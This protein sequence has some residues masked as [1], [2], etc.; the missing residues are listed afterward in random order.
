M[1][2]FTSILFLLLLPLCIATSRAQDSAIAGTYNGSLELQHLTGDIASESDQTLTVTETAEGKINVTFPSINVLGQFAS[3]SFTVED[4]TV[5]PEGDGSYSLGKEQFIIEISTGTMTS[6][7]GYSSLSGTIF[8]NGEAEVIVKV[9]QNPTMTATTATFYGDI[10]DMATP[11]S[12]AY[13][14]GIELTHLTGAGTPLEDQYVVVKK[15]TSNTVNVT[16]PSISILGRT[17]SGTITVTGVGVTAGENGSY[18]LSKNPF[19][20]NVNG[21]M[22]S[23][24]YP[25]SI[26]SGTVSAEG[27]IKLTVEVIQN[28]ALGALTTA[29]FTGKPADNS[30]FVW[31]TAEWSI[32]DNRTFDSIEEFETAGLTLT[33]PNPTGY[34]LTFLNILAADCEVYVDGNAEAEKASFSGQ[35]GTILTTKY[36]FA[37]GHDYK[38]KVISAV[39]AQ[40]NLATRK[41]DTLSINNDSYTLSFRINGPELQKTIEVEAKMS[42]DIIDQNETPTVSEVNVAEITAALGINDISEADM[43]ALNPDGSYNDHMDYYDFWHAANGEFTNYNGGYDTYAGHNAYP[44]VYCIKINEAADSVTYFFY[45]SWKEYD[46]NESGSIPGIGA[47]TENGS[48]S[49]SVVRATPTTS[50]NSIIWDW[51]NGD[52]TTTQYKRSY[53]VDVDND[54]KASF[55]FVANRKS[56]TVNA[57]LHFVEGKVTGIENAKATTASGETEYYTI[58]GVRLSTPQKGINIVRE[59]DGRTHKILVK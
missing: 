17:E 27:E 2:R 50:Y 43:H 46:P 58:D 11:V 47:D 8:A 55:I 13:N 9:A 1:K 25:N 29:V 33:Y 15:S 48:G 44:A 24:S 40:A 49:Q 26:L 20:I 52:G 59:A 41:T 23:S 10:P 35:A 14:G 34:N 42:L 19:T 22:M 54:Y 39:L 3:G 57:T 53:R 16:F 5:T 32:E 21:G 18:T 56:V 45:D 38:I 30:V 28:P 31:G 37:E 36:G 4:V 6:S 12:G 51:D 7:Y